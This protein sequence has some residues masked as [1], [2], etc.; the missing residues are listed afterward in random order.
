MALRARLVALLVS[1]LPWQGQME[2]TG[3]QEPCLAPGHGEGPPSVHRSP[4][5]AESVFQGE[6]AADLA[7]FWF[8]GVHRGLTSGFWVS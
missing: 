8:L 4:G 6:E 2:G 7:A 1:W 3:V 5:R